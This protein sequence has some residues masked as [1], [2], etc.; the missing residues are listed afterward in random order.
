[1]TLLPEDPIVKYPKRAYWGPWC[2]PSWVTRRT[3]SGQVGS[4]ILLACGHRDGRK[5]QYGLGPGLVLFRF[6]ISPLQPGAVGP[7]PIR[8]AWLPSHLSLEG[9]GLYPDF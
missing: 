1:M 5:D 7:Y 9:A 2:V 6:V 4:E 3:Y 8:S